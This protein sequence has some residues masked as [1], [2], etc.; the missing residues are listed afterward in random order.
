MDLR[1]RSHFVVPH[2]AVSCVSSNLAHVRPQSL[3]PVAVDRV[4]LERSYWKREDG[5]PLES[6]WGRPY[7]VR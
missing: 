5:A 1:A 3:L 7:A 6:N 2:S 4:R